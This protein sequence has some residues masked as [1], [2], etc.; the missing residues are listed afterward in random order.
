M[1]DK[2]MVPSFTTAAE[3]SS[4]DVSM[5]RIFTGLVFSLFLEDTRCQAG[6][7]I[8][9]IFSPLKI[10]IA[11]CWEIE[12][13]SLSRRLNCLNHFTLAAISL[14]FFMSTF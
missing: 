5:A 10:F 1:L 6:L 12:S 8:P 9:S 11:F 14:P 4:Q 13:F 3:V 7:L 2:T